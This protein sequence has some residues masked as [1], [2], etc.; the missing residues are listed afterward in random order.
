MFLVASL[1]KVRGRIGGVDVFLFDHGCD[2]RGD[3]RNR[4]CAC[5]NRLGAGYVLWLQAGWV[6]GLKG[7]ERRGLTKIHHQYFL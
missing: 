1:E 5:E 4:A 3:G 7:V 2:L 6:L